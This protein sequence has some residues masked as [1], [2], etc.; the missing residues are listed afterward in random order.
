MFRRKLS[1]TSFVLLSISVAC[2]IGAAVVMRAYAVRLDAA[3]PDGGP[4]VDVVAAA[5]D[6]P[7]GTILTDQLLEVVALP[8]RFLP[9]GAIRDP[10]RVAGRVASA[11]LAEGEVLTQ[12]RLAGG[13]A[14]PTASVV[15]LGMRAVH[16]SVAASVGVRPGDLVDVLAT[17][18]GGGAHTEVTGEALEVLAI[19]RG[20]AGS[21]G[22]APGQ[23]GGIGLVLLVTPTDAERLAFAAT[24]ATLS[25]AVRSPGDV[26]SAQPFAAPAGI[27][28]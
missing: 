2:A 24:F 26:V 22:A 6:V 21:L 8:T 11:D 17:F 12:L 7:R 1:R 4:V 25:I 14:G 13:R 23:T 27:D 28:G 9:P 16:V 15:P 10:G 18:G 20:S 5:G 3:R 19:D